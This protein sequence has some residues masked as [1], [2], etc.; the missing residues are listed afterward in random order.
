M[1][2]NCA[3]RVPFP[4]AIS[5]GLISSKFFPTVAGTVLSFLYPNPVNMLEKRSN[6]VLRKQGYPYSRRFR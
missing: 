2:A 4:F 6:N 1:A 3:I 5:Y